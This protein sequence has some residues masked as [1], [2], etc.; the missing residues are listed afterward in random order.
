MGLMD[1]F[2]SDGTVELKHREYYNL[3]RESAKAE[4]ISNA[5]KAD[6]PGYYIEAMLTG[7]LEIPVYDAELNTEA[8]IEETTEEWGNMV[9]AIRGIFDKRTTEKQIKETSGN[10]LALICEFEQM[11]K[12]ELEKEKILCKQNVNISQEEVHKLLKKQ[13]ESMAAISGIIPGTDTAKERQ[14]ES[15]G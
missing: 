11:R 7:K 5:I 9:S 3:M 13:K 14:E 12:E 8:Q 4:L 10:I 15:E 1:G 2:T 6:V